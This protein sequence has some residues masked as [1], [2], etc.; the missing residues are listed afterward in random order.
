MERSISKPRPAVHNGRDLSYG[1]RSKS[2]AQRAVLAAEDGDGPLYIFRPT[3]AQRAKL[4][5]VSPQTLAAARAL[6]PV[7]RDKVKRGLR[8]LIEPKDP[9]KAAVRMIGTDADVVRILVELGPDRVYHAL[10]EITRPM[11][12]A[13]E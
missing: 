3:N 6:P 1:L 8:R 11:S 12:E 5:K 13:A 9:V 4:F 2:A 7:E 10:E